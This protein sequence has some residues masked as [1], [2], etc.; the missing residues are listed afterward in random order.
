MSRL[1]HPY[2]SPDMKT[3]SVSPLLLAVA[4]LAVPALAQNEMKAPEAADGKMSKNLQ[5]LIKKYDKNGDGKLD[6]DEK[7][8][9]HAAMRKEG[10][11]GAMDRY[12]QI[13]MRF[14]KDGDG[15]LNDAERAEAEKARAMIERNGGEAKFSAMILKRFDK[16]GDGRLD[17]A[18]RAEARKFRDEQIKKFDKDGD[19]K[20][21]D[22]EREEALK[23][24]MAEDAATPAKAAAAVAPAPAAV[25]TPTPEAKKEK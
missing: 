11:G 9:A 16:N 8:A 18:E 22:A 5:E 17:D 19:G 6:E 1:R 4:L 10:A 15:K 14:D 21:N 3:S 20:L 13:L 12:K 24:F 23:A 2:I 7:A 25:A